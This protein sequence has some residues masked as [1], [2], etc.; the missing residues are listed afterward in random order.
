MLGTL[1]KCIISTN[2]LVPAVTLCGRYELFY[3]IYTI[4]LIVLNI[5]KRDNIFITNHDQLEKY[6]ELSKFKRQQITSG[7]NLMYKCQYND[8]CIL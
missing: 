5:L 6:S 2:L 4:Y 8:N 1:T 3:K 7:N